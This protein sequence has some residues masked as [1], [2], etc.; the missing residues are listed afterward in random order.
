MDVSSPDY[1]TILKEARVE[2]DRSI[3]AIKGM[4]N[5]YFGAGATGAREVALSYTKLQEAKMWIGKALEE[6]GHELP[7]EFQDKAE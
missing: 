6:I 4:K 5:G 3:Q 1:V 7:K 2:I